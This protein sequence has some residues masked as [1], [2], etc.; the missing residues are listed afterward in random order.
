MKL[1]Q[2]VHPTF[3]RKWWCLT[4][5]LAMSVAFTWVFQAKAIRNSQPFESETQ[6]DPPQADSDLASCFADLNSFHSFPQGTWVVGSSPWNFQSQTISEH[7]LSREMKGIPGGEASVEGSSH[8]EHQV[9]LD[10]FPATKAVTRNEG[11]LA[12]RILDL[13]TVRACVCYRL[14]ASAIVHATVAH[15]M[16]GDQ[17]Q[18]VRLTPNM[19]HNSDAVHLLP[20]LDACQ[21]H[22]QRFSNRGELQC[23][24]I[25]TDQTL[26][27]LLAYW[28]KNGW[29]VAPA[30]SGSM[31]T[32]QGWICSQGSLA[33]RVQPTTSET[34]RGRILLTALHQLKRN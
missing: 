19:H 32:N 8:P 7:Q 1:N 13:G 4:V 3:P 2:R 18:V 22:C 15:R 12:W 34:N 17:W 24:I 23:E 33:I 29:S 21:S 25:D 26:E 9:V 30:Q 6:V 28:M 11:E 27:E 20:M 16:Q 14:E 31:S 10:L 5:L